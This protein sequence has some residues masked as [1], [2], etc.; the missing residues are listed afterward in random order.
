[1]TT[2]QE[3]TELETI[4]VE[5]P[6]PMRTASRLMLAVAREWPGASVRGDELAGALVFV[7]DPSTG[8]ELDLDLDLADDYRLDPQWLDAHRRYVSERTADEPL[9]EWLARSTRGALDMFLIES[10]IEAGS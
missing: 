1:M 4:R 2:D 7:I 8:L 3:T 9:G 10:A 5:L 6:L